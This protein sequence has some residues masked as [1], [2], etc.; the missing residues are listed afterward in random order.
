MQHVVCQSID[1]SL[2]LV[3]RVRPLAHQ[4]DGVEVDDAITAI[5]QRETEVL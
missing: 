1:G 2:E 3:S 4:V 5:D